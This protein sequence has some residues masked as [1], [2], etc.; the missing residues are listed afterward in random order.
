MIA[1]TITG[2][3]VGWGGVGEPLGGGGV[4]W[5][6]VLSSTLVLKMD[7]N[8]HKNLA[9]SQSY[10]RCNEHVT[11]GGYLRLGVSLN[12]KKGTQVEV[13]GRSYTHVTT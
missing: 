11:N 1:N 2:R 9:D 5:M 4:G 3:G 12:S 7:F 8:K 13:N 10:E 6:S